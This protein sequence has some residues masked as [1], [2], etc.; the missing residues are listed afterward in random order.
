MELGLDEAQRI[1]FFP[2]LSDMR[3][4]VEAFSRETPESTKR[5]ERVMKFKMMSVF[6][7][8]H[9]KDGALCDHF[10]HSGGLCALAEFLGDEHRVI[11]SQ[12]VE[13]FMEMVSPLIQA[14]V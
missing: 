11:Q 1:L 8:L 12:V 5:R 14:P 13:L 6:Y 3:R 7:T 9:R 4:Y 2:R 10:M